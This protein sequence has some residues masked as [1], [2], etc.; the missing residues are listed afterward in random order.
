MKKTKNIVIK[1]GCHS[2]ESLLGISL[3]RNRKQAEN[4]CLKTIRQKGDSRQKPSGMTA[5]FITASGFTLI[6]LLVVVLI[7]GILAAVAMPQY[8]KAVG[9][10]RL[11]EALV[12]LRSI[13]EAVELCELEHGVNTLTDECRNFD[14]IIIELEN[15]S[16]APADYS[17]E[18]SHTRYA[19]Y[20]SSGDENIVATA[21][22]AVVGTHIAEGETNDNP[23]DVCLCMFRNGDIRGVLGDCYEGPSWDILGA[24]GIEHARE[25]EK[26][27][28]C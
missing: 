6:E 23:K 9:K 2:Q 10:S 15:K 11:A 1:K 13:G 3:I 16:K 17:R 5:Y 27:W 12:N 28:C 18:T 22:V 8:Q 4:F 26:C 7:I 21:D 25:G 14:N 20:S 19:T 24:L